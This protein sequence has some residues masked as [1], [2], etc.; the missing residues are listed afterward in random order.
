MS[1]KTAWFIVLTPLAAAGWVAVEL[2]IWLISEVWWIV[3]W[4]ASFHWRARG[5]AMSAAYG[6]N[7]EL[8]DTSAIGY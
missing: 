1:N 4:L 6:L 7:G 2:A 3:E 5:A 8:I